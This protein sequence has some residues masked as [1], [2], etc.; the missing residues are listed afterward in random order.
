MALINQ[1]SLG[2]HYFSIGFLLR[3]S[4][5]VNGILTCAEVWHNFTLK[6]IERLENVDERNL[7]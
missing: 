7:I 1:V 3:E 5:V 2:I 4:N 6:Q